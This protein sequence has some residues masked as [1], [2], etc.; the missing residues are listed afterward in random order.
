MPDPTG[1]LV[2]LACSNRELLYGGLA[3]LLAHFGCSLFTA[4]T[5]TPDPKSL[6]GRLYRGIELVALVA[7]RAKD[8][9]QGD[10]R[11]DRP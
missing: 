10:G 6:L 5:P 11:P 2:D 7:G 9:G 8:T 3:L 1:G 4:A